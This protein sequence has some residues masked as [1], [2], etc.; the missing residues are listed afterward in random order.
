MNHH[1]QDSFCDE[2]AGLLHNYR[3]LYQTQDGVVEKCV[4][5]MCG[6]KQFYPHNT[7]N[8]VYLSSHLRMALQ[9]NDPLFRINFPNFVGI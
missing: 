4:N 6:D 2:D 8:H 7:P 5:A 1:Y 9:Q 3:M